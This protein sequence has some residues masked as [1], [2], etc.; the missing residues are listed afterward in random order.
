M[1][2]VFGA[3]ISCG[4]EVSSA[5]VIGIV[6]ESTTVTG[7]V[8]SVFE[9]D[10]AGPVRQLNCT[11]IR[12][13]IRGLVSDW[14]EGP[15]PLADSGVW[16]LVSDGRL[17]ELLVDGV[18]LALA[19]QV[20]SNGLIRTKE[21]GNWWVYSYNGNSPAALVAADN[22]L[23]SLEQWL[24]SRKSVKDAKQQGRGASPPAARPSNPTWARAVAS[25]Q[26]TN[27]TPGTTESHPNQGQHSHIRPNHISHGP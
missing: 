15:S 26:S 12:L 6:R 22:Q 25:P 4:Q 19:S 7:E 10:P 3:R 20:I 13:V 9:G 5:N 27:E 17:T 18:P 21:F 11:G 16:F 24:Q 23:Q 8:A 14:S 2:M 1:I